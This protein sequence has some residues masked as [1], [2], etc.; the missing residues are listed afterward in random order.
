MQ[1]KINVNQ[2]K[3]IILGAGGAAKAVAYALI[4]LGTRSIRVI[5]RSKEKKDALE[6]WIRN[7]GIKID[8]SVFPAKRAHG[9]L[10]RYRYS[11]PSIININ[12]RTI[13]DH[14]LVFVF[15]P[16]SNHLPVVANLFSLSLSAFRYITYIS[17]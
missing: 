6:N 13:T 15:V 1:N 8:C 9:G 14:I 12:G 4:K 3:C 5:N 11:S 2:Q 17:D 7:Q 16:G 10:P